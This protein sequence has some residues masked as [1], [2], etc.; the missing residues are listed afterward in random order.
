MFKITSTQAVN[1]PSFSLRKGENEFLSR[2]VVPA[3]LWP[4]LARF[5]DLKLLIF[6]GN[7]SAE[8]DEPVKLEE[9]TQR[10]LYDMGKADLVELAKANGISVAGD[11]SKAT[12]LGLLEKRLPE[13]AFPKAGTPSAPEATVVAAA[14]AA[15][16][17]A[18][19]GNK[20]VGKPAAAAPSES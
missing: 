17:D 13:S 9:L 4:K 18:G 14:P 12:V 10:Q 11:A 19:A 7:A 8:K 6:E 20:R 16:V 15:P 2:K 5:R 1:W 3:E